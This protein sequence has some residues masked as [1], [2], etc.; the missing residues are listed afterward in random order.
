MTDKKVLIIDDDEELCEEL[1]EILKDEGLSVFSVYNGVEGKK[2]LLDGHYDL[3]LLDIKIPGLNGFEL[4]RLLKESNIP[5]RI[6]ILTGRPLNEELSRHIIDNLHEEDNL[7]EYA[8]AVMNKPF[9]I[10][11]LIKKIILLLS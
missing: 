8:D 7:L 10:I 6:I 4:L 3:V 11:K 9:S 5:A 2:E 1:E